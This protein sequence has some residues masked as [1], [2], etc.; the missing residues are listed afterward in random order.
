MLAIK[1]DTKNGFMAV[2]KKVHE[3]GYLIRNIKPEYYNSIKYER[4]IT[5]FN[6][7]TFEYSNYL[8][9]NMEVVSALEY[10]SIFV[11]HTIL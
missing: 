6:N 5:L 1:C 2:L 4:I 7:K 9:P 8:E 10:L 11:S 3:E